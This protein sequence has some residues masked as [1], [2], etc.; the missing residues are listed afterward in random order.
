MIFSMKIDD[1]VSKSTHLLEG[2]QIE[3][4]S[5]GNLATYYSVQV[6]CESR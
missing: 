6:V 3:R 2:L 5:M 1:M 4:S